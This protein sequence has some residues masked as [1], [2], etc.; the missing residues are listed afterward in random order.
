METTVW[1]EIVDKAKAKGQVFT[2]FKLSNGN[3]LI[4]GTLQEVLV[5]TGMGNGWSWRQAKTISEGSILYGPNGD[6]VKI[7]ACEEKK[8]ERIVIVPTMAVYQNIFVSGVLVKAGERVKAGGLAEDTL[9]DIPNEVAVK[10]QSLRQEKP[11]SG[12]LVDHNMPIPTLLSSIKLNKVKTLVELHYSISGIKRVLRVAPNQIIV[13]FLPKQNILT[14][15]VALPDLESPTSS[16]TISEDKQPKRKSKIIQLRPGMNLVVNLSSQGTPPECVTL[17]NLSAISSDSLIKS[18]GN[19]ND[20]NTYILEIYNLTMVRAEGILVKVLTNYENITGIRPTA[21]II[22]PIQGTPPGA[23]ISL[24]NIDRLPQMLLRQMKPIDD[25]FLTTTWPAKTWLADRTTAKKDFSALRYVELITDRGTLTCGNF[26]RVK[27]IRKSQLG[28]SEIVEIHAEKIVDTPMQWKLLYL[29]AENPNPNGELIPVPVKSARFHYS[30]QRVSF[31]QLAGNGLASRMNVMRDEGRVVISKDIYFANGFLVVG[32][33]EETPGGGG[34]VSGGGQNGIA[35]PDPSIG[36][37]INY[38]QF[39]LPGLDASERAFERDRI[40]FS[41]DELAIFRQNMDVLRD[42]YSNDVRWGNIR[43]EKRLLQFL[44]LYFNSDSKGGFNSSE[45][46]YLIKQYADG[47][48]SKAPAW[49]KEAYLDYCQTRAVLLEHGSP[50]DLYRLVFHYV[51][52]LTIFYET[53]NIASGDALR[54]DF[55]CITA[56]IA[57]GTIQDQKA[58]SEYYKDRQYCMGEALLWTRDVT[59]YIRN[60]SEDLFGGNPVTVSPKGWEQVL[61]E[62]LDV[63]TGT[64]EATQLVPSPGQVDIGNLWVQLYKY[65]H[66]TANSSDLE[67]A[68]FYS[69]VSPSQDPSKMFSLER[70]EEGPYANKSI[71]ELL[72]IKVSKLNALK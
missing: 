4:V 15:A 36:E 40:K 38:V 3:S 70:F 1:A 59:F 13:V 58:R 71:R 19:D 44:A 22:Q 43:N 42:R 48:K 69:I 7:E 33:Q 20:K 23:P 21:D 46:K 9:V 60:Q 6:E 52:L 2:H 57:L 49:T 28:R 61:M 12:F 25:S 50:A 30:P 24:K 66:G 29:D 62:K 65:F 63:L 11:I 16:T 53:G 64:G 35:G 68:V 8:E 18:D 72:G 55:L 56:H 14:E 41:N 10:V 51:F 26:Q 54:D 27:A 34:S 37:S 17:D 5:K 32:L 47:G 39:N 67:S 45:K 31:Q